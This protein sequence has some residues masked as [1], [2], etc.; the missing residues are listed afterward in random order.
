[1]RK[2]RSW[3]LIWIVIGMGAYSLPQA[4]DDASSVPDDAV[5]IGSDSVEVTAGEVMLYLE[6]L[7]IKSGVPIGGISGS[8]VSQAVIELYALK[9]VDDDAAGTQLYS[10]GLAAWLPAH[11]LTENRVA[12]FIELSVDKAMLATDWES[13]AREYYAVNLDDFVV[14]ET[15]TVRTLLLRTESRSMEEALAIAESLLVDRLPEQSFESLVDEYSEDEAGREAQGLM[16]NMAR[17][18]TVPS[19]ERAA[20]SLS[21]PGQLSDPVVSNFGVHL[22]QLVDKSPARTRS[23]EEVS[24]AIVRDLKRSRPADYRTAIQSEARS[25]EPAGHKVNEAA[26]DAFMNSLGHTKLTVPKA[27]NFN[28]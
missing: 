19:F 8:R 28:E 4:A 18:E 1:M 11:L 25:R 27:P 3:L 5:L 6:W 16:K 24:A 14:P 12:R 9:L 22:I 15:I 21:E 20:F 7:A 10:P 17:G 23:F 26:V 13:E 2:S